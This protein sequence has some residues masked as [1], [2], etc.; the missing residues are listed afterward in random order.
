ML[1][2]P[3]IPLHLISYFDSPKFVMVIVKLLISWIYLYPCL[4]Q[5]I[6]VSLPGEAVVAPPGVLE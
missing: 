6:F 1:A 3:C 4:A 5:S 2:A